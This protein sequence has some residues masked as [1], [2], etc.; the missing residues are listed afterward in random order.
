MNLG[1]IYVDVANNTCDVVV[2]VVDANK[3]LLVHIKSPVTYSKNLLLIRAFSRKED[4][5]ILNII[6]TGYVD[7]ANNNF[8]VVIVVDADGDLLVHIKSPVTYSKTCYLFKN[9][10]LIQK[11][12][13]YST[14][15]NI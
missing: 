3:D 11:P 2:V 4:F 15:I 14:V 8:D 5:S 7:V 9:L 12:F 1:T 10:L 13:I 6:Q